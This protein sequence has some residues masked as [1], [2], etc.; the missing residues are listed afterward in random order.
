MTQQTDN[1]IRDA[2]AAV[3]RAIAELRAMGVAVPIALHLAVHAMAYAEPDKPGLPACHGQG[4]AGA[5]S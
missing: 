4:H 1:P 2:R 5:F 3:I